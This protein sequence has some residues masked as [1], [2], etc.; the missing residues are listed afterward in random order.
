MEWLIDSLPRSPVSA[1]AGIDVEIFKAH[2]T[3]AASCS[4]AKNDG[5]P[6]ENILRTAGW[7]NNSTFEKFYDKIIVD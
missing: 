5:I 1:K 3:R 6:I 2:S 4:R 7:A